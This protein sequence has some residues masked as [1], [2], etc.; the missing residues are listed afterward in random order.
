MLF[1]ELSNLLGAGEIEK[2][3]CKFVKGFRRLNQCN[4]LRLRLKIFL[5]AESSSLQA[6]ESSFGK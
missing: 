3:R 2:W 4:F 1:A 6:W 5:V